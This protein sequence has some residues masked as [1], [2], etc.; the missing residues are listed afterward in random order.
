MP[1]F[2]FPDISWL[3][4]HTY[5]FINNV[6]WQ[7]QK[8]DYAIFRKRLGM[9]PVKGSLINKTVKDKV[10]IIHAFSPELISRP[11]DWEDQYIISG[12]FNQPKEINKAASIPQDLQEWIKAGEKPLYIGFGS[13]P[14]P[15]T[16]LISKVIIGLLAAGVRIIYCQGWS[17]MPHVPKH[18]NLFI[19]KQTDHAW[20]LP[21]CRAAIIHGGIGTVAAVLNADIPAIVTPLFVDQPVWAQMVQQKKLGVSI[22]WR[23]L[24]AAAVLNALDKIQEPSFVDTMNKAH[25]R[26]KQEDGIGKAI[27]IIEAYCTPG[28]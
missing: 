13:I 3:N 28:L 9:Q 19:I 8:K 20:L 12:F 10:P 1:M 21:K 2:N 26:L 5:T 7:V 23:K 11:D 24:T 17:D 25:E 4:P 14:F 18:P 15:D 27:K 16:V 6:L 22:P